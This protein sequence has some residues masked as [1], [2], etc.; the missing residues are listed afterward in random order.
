MDQEDQCQA[1]E[2]FSFNQAQLFLVTSY[3]NH[4]LGAGGPGAAA[5]GS[6]GQGPTIEEVD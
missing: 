1:S 6:G 3:V 5:G 2:C 4:L